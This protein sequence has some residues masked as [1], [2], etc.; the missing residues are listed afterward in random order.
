MRQTAGTSVRVSQTIRAQ[1]ERLFRAW[2]DPNEL[3]HWWRMEGEGWAFAGA[4]LELRVGGRYQLAMT[5][6]EGKKYVAAG[7]YRDVYAPTRLAFTWDWEDPEQRVGETLVTVEFKA[8]G[9]DSTEVVITHER[10][11][12][13][14]RAEGHKS[15]W[16]QLLRLLGHMVEDETT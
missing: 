1:P 2:T 11:D 7:V 9:R 14:K 4:V 10:F 15:G 5:S 8:I 13:A 6:P 12:D 3:Q 16:G